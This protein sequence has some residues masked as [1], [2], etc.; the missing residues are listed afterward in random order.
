MQTTR[1]TSS[2]ILLILILVLTAPI[3]LTIGGVF[4]G[5]FGGI[6]GGLFG[7]IFGVLGGLLGAFF[8]LIALPFKVVFG[9][10]DFF[11]GDWLLSENTMFTI[12]LLILIVALFRRRTT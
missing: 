7:V 1:S 5:V 12:V 10:F 11:D 8:G 9:S 6:L 4:I 3:W 2:T